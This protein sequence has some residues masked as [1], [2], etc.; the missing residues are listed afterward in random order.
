MEASPR[1]EG[2][3]LCAAAARKSLQYALPFGK[4]D[5]LME[6]VGEVLAGRGDDSGLDNES[7]LARAV[8]GPD[9]D[10]PT[11]RE[12]YVLVK[13]R[14]DARDVDVLVA[15]R[16][17]LKCELEV[18]REKATRLQGWHKPQA[19][20]DWNR[21]E[22]LRLLRDIAETC[23]HL[24]VLDVAIEVYRRRY[25]LPSLTAAAS[26]EAEDATILDEVSW[27][28]P[29]TRPPSLPADL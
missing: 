11:M 14:L 21:P 24:G 10:P 19:G 3:A 8:A 2:E 15:D 28:T 26:I 29:P 23:D 18:F 27:D 4:L 22:K 12:R 17:A 6:L 5:V 20:D 7:G 13:R 25:R 16:D 9:F 1:T